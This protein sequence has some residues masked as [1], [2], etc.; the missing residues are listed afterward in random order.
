[1]DNGGSYLRSQRLLLRCS[2]EAGINAVTFLQDPSG[3]V[4][5]SWL[6]ECGWLKL[7]QLVL[8]YFRLCPMVT[9]HPSCCTLLV[10][11]VNVSVIIS[12]LSQSSQ[13]QSPSLL[14]L[15]RRQILNYACI[16]KVGE[17]EETNEQ[18]ERI[19]LD[20]QTQSEFD[21]MS[22]CLSPVYSYARLIISG[23]VWL[24]NYLIWFN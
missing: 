24:I 9:L 17:K 7:R 12:L 8:P 20:S 2:K 23:S 16:S 4:D 11:S 18:Q 5:I 22:S 1:M 21:F 6:S 13:Y 10:T 14:V 19:W 15:G 3:S